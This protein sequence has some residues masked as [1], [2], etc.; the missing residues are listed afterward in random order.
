MWKIIS[1][2]SQPCVNG[3][4]VAIIIITIVRNCLLRKLKPVTV[5][6]FTSNTSQ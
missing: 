6:P 5:K 3:A 4:A 2:Q 1:A